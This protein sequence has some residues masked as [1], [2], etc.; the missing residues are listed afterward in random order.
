MFHEH[1]GSRLSSRPGLE[2]VPQQLLYL[3]EMDLV[4]KPRSLKQT[5]VEAQKIHKAP[6]VKEE[7]R[8]VNNNAKRLGR[9]LNRFSAEEV[10][11]IEKAIV[12]K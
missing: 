6:E 4:K 9:K 1:I 8:E 7:K 2:S 11:R 10:L 5:I 12:N 3:I